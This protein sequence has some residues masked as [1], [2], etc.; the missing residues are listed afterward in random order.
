MTTRS[1]DIDTGFGSSTAPTA[2]EAASAT[3][4]PIFSQVALKDS[5]Y[6]HVDNIT[7]VKAISASVRVDGMIVAIDGQILYQFDSDSSATPDDDEILQP[8]SGSGRWHKVTSGAGASASGESVESIEQHCDLRHDG[9]HVQ[10]YDVSLCEGFSEAGPTVEGFLLQALSSGSSAITLA[11]NPAFLDAANKNSQF[12]A[13]YA[14]VTGT[15]VANINTEGTLVK[16]GTSTTSFDKAGGSSVNAF[17]QH[18]VGAANAVSL[19]G[20][21]QVLVYV[22]MPSTTNLS[23]I[24]IRLSAEGDDPTNYEQYNASVQF[25]G[26]AFAAGWNLVGFDLDGSSTTVGTGWAP[27]TNLLRTFAIG[28]VASSAAQ[29]YTNIV[30]DSLVFVADAG[31]VVTPTYKQI[32]QPGMAYTITDTSNREQIIISSAATRVIG[33]TTLSANATNSY[34]GGTSSVVMRSQL[35][36]AGDNRSRYQSTSPFLGATL[37]SGASNLTQDVRVSKHLKESLTNGTVK[38]SIALDTE[39]AF[40]VI[41]TPTSTTITVVD[42]VNYSAQLL[43]T[44]TM[45]IVYVYD[46]NGKRYY[47]YGSDITL[48]ANSSHSGST[49]T[50]TASSG[51]VT[52]V[53][54]AI[55]AASAVKLIKAG[56][57]EA[58]L[59]CVGATSNESFGSAMT[60]DE[61]IISDLG[62]PYPKASAIF[63]HYLK[64]T[65]S[66]NTSTFGADNRKGPGPDL[67]V[68][69]TG[70]ASFARAFKNGQL[71]AGVFSDTN[72]LT[73]G[74]AL[75][76]TANLNPD[77]GGVGRI[78]ASFWIYPVATPGAAE[79]VFTREDTVNGYRVYVDTSRRVTLQF[80]GGSGAVAVSAVMSLNTWYHCAVL[81]EDG[82]SSALWLNGVK[83]SASG[84]TITASS[85]G[86]LFIGRANTGTLSLA[87]NYIADLVFWS[88]ALGDAAIT[89]SDVN[90]IYAGGQH[91]YLGSRA[92]LTYRYES[93]AL[94]GQKLSVR[95]QAL[96]TT[97]AV[98]PFFTR[99]AAIKTN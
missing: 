72:Y 46:N 81:M 74:T 32:A 45:H 68:Q 62:L 6:D 3:D 27:E 4:T 39:L 87:S 41:D 69:G 79:G 9:I 47:V 88:A 61:L 10:E 7:A 25:D 84:N 1:F 89:D 49:L 83:T 38:T 19:A 13:G 96:R 5:W 12:E 57:H 43:D 71:A 78:A 86:A 14:A 56:Q 44:H 34:A 82:G 75:A 80:L 52:A 63:G 73:V 97:S 23:T 21:R 30:F 99:V 2:E 66:Q 55:A 51:H 28:V 91:R 20:N 59:S 98:E 40:D 26:T 93:T 94:S 65:P 50:L 31:E 29:T 18:D 60:K 76:D 37:S 33:N 35:G 17:I 64:L 77:T 22:N 24:S 15:D 95:A 8:T 54:N 90:A 92:G 58:Y 16:I 53:D 70:A 85:A 48:T 67:T 36:I 42:T 11:W